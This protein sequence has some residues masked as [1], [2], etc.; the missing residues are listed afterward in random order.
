MGHRA[1]NPSKFINKALFS[2]LENIRLYLRVLC[3]QFM[4]QKV[5]HM[6]HP[7]SILKNMDTKVIIINTD[8]IMGT[9]T[10]RVQQVKMVLSMVTLLKD[11]V[12]IGVQVFKAWNLIRNSR[13][14]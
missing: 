4:R 14:N 5:F 2:N 3:R 11:A 8:T 7:H 9:D 1:N 6:R 13:I 10:T 12:C